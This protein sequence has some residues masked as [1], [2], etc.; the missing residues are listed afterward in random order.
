M[1]K[2]RP[3]VAIVGCGFGGIAAA[4]KLKRAGI[5]NFTI[6][7]KAEGVGGTW[8]VNRY[9]GAE[10]DVASHL[11]SYPFARRDWTRTHA[12]R[13]ELQQYLESVVDRY[14]LRRHIRLGTEVKA[15]V[16]VEAM[17]GYELTLEGGEVARVNAGDRTGRGPRHSVPA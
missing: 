6:Y 16:W 9:P 15:A 1:T 4:V 14:D 5:E 7:E 2:N 8:W 10:V 12:R 17:G 3:S 13:E 11:Y